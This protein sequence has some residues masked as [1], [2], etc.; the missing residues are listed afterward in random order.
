M[1]LYSYASTTSV[2]ERMTRSV[3]N[4]LNRIK[5][6]SVADHAMHGTS[7]IPAIKEIRGGF[8]GFGFLITPGSALLIW[9]LSMVLVMQLGGIAPLAR[10]GT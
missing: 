4:S 10:I 9:F 7:V 5:D 1:I 3:L 8:Y 2:W 6:V